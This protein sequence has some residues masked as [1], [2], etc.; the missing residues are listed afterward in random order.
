[1]LSDLRMMVQQRPPDSM[2]G[3]VRETLAAA[4]MMGDSLEE[5]VADRLQL[6]KRTMQ[7]QLETEGY[8]F[9]EILSSFRADRAKELLR[10]TD[11]SVQEIAASLGY[12]EVN[13]F[14]RAFRRLVGVTP[15][16]FSSGA[17]AE[18]LV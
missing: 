13:S 10:E 11:L 7:R 1:M 6:G 4:I 16:E 5:A 18:K 8:T 9:R 15:T 17:S 14:R 12:L 3:L 2:A